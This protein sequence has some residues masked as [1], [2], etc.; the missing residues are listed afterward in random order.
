MPVKVANKLVIKA[1]CAI[2]MQINK[3]ASI[4]IE[5]GRLYLFSS[6]FLFY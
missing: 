4:E 1:N 2:I 5:F 3:E 6:C